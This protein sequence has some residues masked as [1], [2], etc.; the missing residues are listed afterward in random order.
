MVPSLSPWLVWRRSLR[1]STDT[2]PHRF[3]AGRAARRGA[4]GIVCPQQQS[5][6]R[7]PR[8][9]GA[10][11]LTGTLRSTSCISARVNGVQ[12]YAE[13]PVPSTILIGRHG[14]LHMVVLERRWLT[15]AATVPH[16]EW[17][18]RLLVAHRSAGIASRPHWPPQRVPCR[19]SQ[20]GGI[21]ASPSASWRRYRFTKTLIPSQAGAD[22]YFSPVNAEVHRL[23]GGAGSTR[24]TP[25]PSGAQRHCS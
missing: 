9:K 12:K 3:P 10:E 17:Y 19:G 8:S 24:Y 22:A 25:A 4:P 21:S 6:Q 16:T 20:R 7:R 2:V 13:A 18:R 23:C 14:L 15:D 1:R 5:R 11:P